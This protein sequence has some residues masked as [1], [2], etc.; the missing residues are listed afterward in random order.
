MSVI[1]FEVAETREYTLKADKEDPT[2]WTIGRI[3]H[4]LWSHLQDKNSRMEVNGLGGE[5]QGSVKFDL[6]TRNDDFVRFGLKGWKNLKDKNGNEVP[7]TT[8]SHST[9]VGNRHGLSDLLLQKI[10]PFIA[11][12][13][14]EIER[15]NGMTGEEV[16]N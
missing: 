14:A 15:F 8:V 4:R 6:N 1:V 3:D 2:S 12:L 10:R 16:K 11:E 9:A 13:A 7:F 5:A